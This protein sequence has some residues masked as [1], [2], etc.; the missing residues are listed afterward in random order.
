MEQAALR[1]L[2][3]MTGLTP[4][5]M[6]HLATQA[7]SMLNNLEIRLANIE[8]KVEEI[9]SYTFPIASNLLEDKSNVESNSN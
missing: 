1:M 3:N 8:A 7:I 6:Q 9:H 4:D 2:Q 5:Q